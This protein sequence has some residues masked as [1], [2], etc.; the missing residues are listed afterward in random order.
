MPRLA[1]FPA[2][3]SDRGSTPAGTTCLTLATAANGI[4]AR[5]HWRTFKPCATPL[6]EAAR[7]PPLAGGVERQHQKG[8]HPVSGAT[9]LVAALPRIPPDAR[10]RSASRRKR[11]IRTPEGIGVI[12]T[13]A[14][15]NPPLTLIVRGSHAARCPSGRGSKSVDRRLGPLHIG[16][17]R[18]DVLEPGEIFVGEV[19]LQRSSREL[20]F[21]M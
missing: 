17:L 5:K 14:K 11:R 10:R 3:S 16:D 7:F 20:E 2:G 19:L 15:A 6:R 13:R 21:L 9:R 18:L 1:K 8:Q 4:S 12:T